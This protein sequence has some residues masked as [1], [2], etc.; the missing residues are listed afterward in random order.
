MGKC[1]IHIFNVSLAGTRI[2][3]YIHVMFPAY[4]DR[5]N[6][7]NLLGRRLN[8]RIGPVRVI[9]LPALGQVSIE[10]SEDER[11][12]PASLTMRVKGLPRPMPNV[13][14][15][16]PEEV[17]LIFPMRPD[18]VVPIGIIEQDEDKVECRTVGRVYGGEWIAPQT[19]IASQS[20]I[21][22]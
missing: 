19:D 14:L 2:D 15:V 21:A 6:L 9:E 1:S 4:K 20:D 10:R 17:A 22:L 7:L 8:I 13:L 3:T 11:P 16:V 12:F 5:P 18:L